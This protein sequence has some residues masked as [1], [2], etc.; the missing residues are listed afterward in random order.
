M[1]TMY[2]HKPIWVDR[3]YTMVLRSSYLVNIIFEMF[4]LPPSLTLDERDAADGKVNNIIA[5]KVCFYN[6]LFNRNL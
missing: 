6:A 5:K 4:F 3:S 2:L 1:R